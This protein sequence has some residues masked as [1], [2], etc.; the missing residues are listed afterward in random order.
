[1]RNYYGIALVLLLVVSS[2]LGCSAKAVGEGQGEG[3]LIMRLAHNQGENHPIHTSLSEFASLVE[4]KS[5]GRIDMKVY[6]GGQLGSEREAIELTQTG[7]I[8]FA[9]VSASTV[10]NFSEEYSIFSLPYLFDGE[11]H[12]YK[13]MNSSIA[14]EL[15][16][17]TRDIGFRGL[18]FYDSG[19]RHFY[20]KDTPILHPDDLQGLKI[21]V[22]PTPTT[23]E[24]IELMGGAPTPMPFGEVYTSLQQGVIDGTENNETALT[25]A[26]HGEVAKEYSFSGHA[27]VPDILIINE[28]K[29]NELTK[30]QRNLI[31][32]AAEES[33]VFHKEVWRKAVESAIVKS[34]ENGVTFHEV[35]KEPFAEAVQPLHEEFAAKESTADYYKEIREMST[36]GTKGE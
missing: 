1:M 19:T 24:M 31:Q 13:V 35:D 33:T 27:I 8:D 12:F 6:P 30:D 21:R 36:E 34:K 4:E 11:D 20:T 2:L 14:E 29:W 15:Y 10:E 5:E 22:Q 32:E 26:N 7:A 18:T 23:I 9:K 28:K 3:P 17:E 16:D 25:D